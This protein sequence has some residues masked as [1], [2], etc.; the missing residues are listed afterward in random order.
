VEE[1]HRTP[2]EIVQ[3]EGLARVNDDTAIRQVCQEVLAEN[4]KEVASYKAGKTTLAAWFVGQVM[5]KMR[6][7]ADPSLARSILEDL[8]KG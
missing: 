4:P 8:L 5:R 1:T 2:R 3:S 6:G 7:K